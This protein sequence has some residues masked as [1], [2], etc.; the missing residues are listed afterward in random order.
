MRTVICL[1]PHG[2]GR[3]QTVTVCDPVVRNRWHMNPRLSG[4]L[5]RIC[6]FTVKTWLFLNLD[7]SSRKSDLLGGNTVVVV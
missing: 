7:L 5:E 3:L 6:K 4:V 1:Y 2:H